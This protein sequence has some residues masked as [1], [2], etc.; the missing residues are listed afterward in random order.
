MSLSSRPRGPGHPPADISWRLRSWI[1]YWMLKEATKQSDDELDRR[2]LPSGPRSGARPRLFERIR[3]IG[4]DPTCPRVDLLNRSI[5]ERVHAERDPTIE[6]ARAAFESPL[7]RMLSDSGMTIE[8]YRHVITQIIAARGWYRASSEDRKLGVTFMPDDPAF[9]M[10]EDRANVYSTMLT[11]LESTPSADNIALLAALFR[12]ALAGVALEQAIL[13]RSSLRVCAAFWTRAIALPDPLSELLDRLIDERIVRNLWRSPAIPAEAKK[14]QRLYVRALI[15]RHL[16]K[17]PD[18]DGP[19][20]AALPIV[21]RSPRI[22]WLCEH[23]SVLGA[24]VHIISE[25][26]MAHCAKNRAAAH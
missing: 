5:F 20:Q 12:E 19:M 17:A 2:Y 16:Q 6:P 1:W 23:R 18:L 10:S 14:S 15:Q 3:S 24:A 26:S 8:D 4:S 25:A 11:S 21:R 22:E 7:W 13:L 9:G